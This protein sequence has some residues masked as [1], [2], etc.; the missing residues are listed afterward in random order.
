MREIFRKDYQT[1][2]ASNCSE[3][4][5]ILREK[6]SQI[7]VIILDIV[8]P[9]KNDYKIMEVMKQDSVLSDIPIVVVTS[10]DDTESEIKVLD[11]G[12]TDIITKPYDPK[13]ISQR[14]K[15]IIQKREYNQIKLENTLLKE[16]NIAQIQL[17]AIMDNMVGGIAL[18]KYKNY[19]EILYANSGYEKY[20]V[21]RKIKNKE[22]PFETIEDEDIKKIKEILEK[23]I[24]EG[25]TFEFEYRQKMLNGDIRWIH[26]NGALIDY[27][28]DKS[29]QLI[30]ILTNINKM[31]AV[32]KDLENTN[33]HLNTL[34]NNVPVGIAILNIENGYNVTFV[35]NNM[36]EFAGCDSPDDFIGK[37][38]T[39]IMDYVYEVDRDRVIREARESIKKTN[40]LRTVVRVIDY[41]GKLN[42][43]S[44]TASAI[45]YEDRYQLYCIISDFTKEKLQEEEI[46]RNMKELEYRANYDYLTGIFNSTT[47]S[48]VTSQMIENNPD[49]EYLIIRWNISQFKV[50]NDIYGSKH[51][52]ELLIK[53]AKAF[54]KY[55]YKVGTYSRYEGDNFVTCFAKDSFDL[56]DLHK[57]ITDD[58]E[59]F[60]HNKELVIYAGVYEVT[61]EQNV[62]VDQMCDRASLTL[63]YSKIE[64]SKY[65]YY[66][67]ESIRSRIL[68]ERDIVSEMEDAI[69]N[70][71]FVIYLQ[72][73][74]SIKKNKTLSA[75]ALVRWIHPKKGF[76]SPGAF[77]PIFERN[78]FIE[79]LDL[80]VL[81]ETCK[82]VK[83]RIS[84]GK[85]VVPI[86]TNLSRMTIY[87]KDIVNKID[88]L[89][90][91]YEIDKNYIRLEITES[92]YI[93]SPN[94]I[95]R[96]V[97][98]FKDKGFKILMDDFGS[99][100][101]S[102]NTLMDI[103]IDILKI[104][105]KLSENIGNSN[106]TETI[107]K[108][109]I[110]MAHALDTAVI[111]EGVETKIQVD[112]YSKTKCDRI[113]GYFFS[114]PLPIDKFNEYIENE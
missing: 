70:K 47:F 79:K 108:S 38:G 13:V 91:K 84:E 22:N 80:Y 113:Q 7:A 15:N 18:F 94:E 101:S 42:W 48:I 2:E 83:K 82:Y 14:V 23:S 66:Y 89:V 62:K 31:K 76:M 112:F 32:E 85:K 104:D 56:Y 45:M 77:V 49:K 20:V 72:P 67:D 61:K 51:G 39:H 110:D 103:P 35:N 68:A 97:K 46:E 87:T 54:N 44:M 86:S 9:K 28:E 99:G 63:K 1:M 53:I 92:A 75:E 6:S 98:E 41:K 30:A 102:L 73:V 111:I 10:M 100:Y 59:E 33:T 60:K 93:E 8:M 58:I 5:N 12:A 40:L 88:T 114:K 43:V 81:E 50:F 52:N 106:R 90:K 107:L 55:L 34:I 57:K 17:A 64:Y 109:I 65:F 27:D 25:T 11:M 21:G 3:A 36:A 29:P 4:L 69:K 19:P 24:K 71:E 78:G 96:I 74:H 26:L 16:Q 105:M 95:I 37:Y